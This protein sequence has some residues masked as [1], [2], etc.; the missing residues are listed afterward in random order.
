[1]DEI[2]QLILEI[3]DQKRADLIAFARDMYQTGEP[4]F[5]EFETSRKAASIMKGLGLPLTENLAITGWKAS[6]P[7]QPGVT[8]AAIGE[9]DGIACPNHPFSNPKNKISHACGHHCQ[10]TALLGC[11]AALSHPTVRQ[12]LCGNVDF[13][14]VP[15][16]EYTDLEYKIGLM[17]QG[18]IKYGGGKSEMIRLGLFDHVQICVAHH[19]HMVDTTQ[20]VLLGLHTTN[21]F[22]VKYV[23]LSGRASHAAI[24]PHKGIN[25]LN[26]ASLGLNALAFQRETF[27]DTDFVRVHSIIC[28]G[29]NMVNVVPDRVVVENQVRAKNMAAML[30]ASA[31][32]NRAFE[33]GAHAIGARLSITDY[34]GYLPILEEPVCKA[35]QETGHLLGREYSI[36][37]IDTSVHNCA[38]TDLG[39]LSHL[40]PVVGF[41][42]GGFE[43][44]LHSADF[45]ILDED[46]AYV[47]PAKIMALTIYNLLKNQA[48]NAKEVIET[49]PQHLTKQE[50]LAYMD[51]FDAPGQQE[52][53]ENQ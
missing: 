22:L 44:A 27:R 53:A 48:Q 16:E 34:A 1:M 23:T 26:A 25:A 51:G 5:R 24:A 18:K 52:K 4:G 28:E 12:A 43:G 11:A 9:L 41:T 17:K 13:F 10:M 36:E 38:S 46:K 31:K 37:D 2:Q 39:D 8:V 29:G 15:S 30:D 35:L 19:L 40:M 50:Y 21:G 49:F 3:I 42:T 7:Q 6:L 47:L 20:D 14:A 32:T 45:R 33:G